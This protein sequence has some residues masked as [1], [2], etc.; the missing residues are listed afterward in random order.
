LGGSG[1]TEGS[2]C[3]AGV[4]ATDFSGSIVRRPACS[5]WGG[6]WYVIFAAWHLVVE[7]LALPA[8]LWFG[9]FFP[10]RW[11]LDVRFPWVKWIVLATQVSALVFYLWIQYL[12]G[13]AASDH[14]RFVGMDRGWAGLWAGARWRASYSS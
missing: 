14:A 9:L 12:R 13:F 6:F 1:K 8:L 11:R 5:W 7:L 10:E 2:Q 3:V 4:T